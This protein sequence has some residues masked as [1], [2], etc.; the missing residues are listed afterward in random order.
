YQD[1]DKKVKASP[2]TKYEIASNTKAF[3]GLAILKLAQEGR[4]NLNDA[5][6]KHVPHFK[7]NY[8]GQNE[9]ITI[10]Q[11][12]AQT[13]GIP[14]DITSEDSV[15]SKRNQ[16]TDVAS[17]IMGDELHHKPGEEFEYSNMNYDLLG[18]IIQN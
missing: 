16:L 18:L 1:V 3:T 4:L 5:V 9:T 2:T 10:K 17:A 15:T 8:N 12:L 13:S 11:L 6:S 7:M 14:S